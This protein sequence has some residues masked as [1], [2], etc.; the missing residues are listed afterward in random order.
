MIILIIRKF[1]ECV[2]VGIGSNK[3]S[4][5][6][7]PF[8]YFFEFCNS[9][10]DCMF[11]NNN[12]IWKFIRNFNCY[13]GVLVFIRFKLVAG[14]KDKIVTG[15]LSLS[16]APIFFF[17]LTTIN[18]IK[19]YGKSCV[20]FCGTR[21]FV[22]YFLLKVQRKRVLSIAGIYHWCKYL[23]W[24]VRN[25]MRIFILRSTFALANQKQ[26]LCVRSYQ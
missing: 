26:I 24:K 21:I 16:R 11:F 10:Q 7:Y 12:F 8:N 19:N 4:A 1:F 9:I 13:L 5:Y 23:K 3:H 25:F 14:G 15:C 6:L 20:F 22:F 2:S 18:H 17:S